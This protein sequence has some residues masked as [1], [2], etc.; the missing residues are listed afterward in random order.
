M[1]SRLTTVSSSSSLAVQ[2]FMSF[3]L[4]NYF[5]PLFPL[6]RPLFPVLHSHLSQVPLSLLTDKPDICLITDLP[7]L[8]HFLCTECPLVFEF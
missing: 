5:F 7:T 4:L 3:G 8:Y 2:F 6:L 1:L